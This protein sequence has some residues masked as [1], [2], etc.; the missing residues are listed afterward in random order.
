MLSPVDPMITA[1]R[2]LSA[3][4]EVLFFKAFDSALV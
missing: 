1:R 4:D 2:T 3:A